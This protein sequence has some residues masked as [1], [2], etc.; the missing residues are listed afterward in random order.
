MK[1]QVQG[2]LTI[3]EVLQKIA[4]G[5][6]LSSQTER[7]L[8]DEIRGHLEDA[9]DTAVQRGQNPDQALRQVAENFGV[10]VAAKALQEEHA[11]W[12]SADAIVA[13]ILPV[14]GTLILRWLTFVPDG[15]AAGWSRLLLQPILWAGAIMVLVTSY[16]YF[17]RWRMALAIW[18]FFWVLSLIF[19]G[20]GME[21]Q[22]A[23]PLGG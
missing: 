17:K 10:E 22:Q 6:Q 8:L 9:R 20:F 11:P 2:I 16:L 12:E 4:A 5:L 13:C 3:E 7:E 14:A 21:N 19:I 23:A 18:G 15:S 1:K